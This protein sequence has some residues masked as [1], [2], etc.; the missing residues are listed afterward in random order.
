MHGKDSAGVPEDMVS[1]I[2][3]FPN[4]LS[5]YITNM[6]ANCIELRE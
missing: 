1:T 5:F 6:Y 4:K 3:A 2:F